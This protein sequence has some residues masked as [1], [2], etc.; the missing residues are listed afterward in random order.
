MIKW[1]NENG[2]KVPTA[3]YTY[4]AG[5]EPT[6]YGSPTDDNTFDDYMTDLLTKNDFP[7]LLPPM[8]GGPNTDIA[9]K[10]SLNAPSFAEAFLKFMKGTKQPDKYS[11]RAWLMLAPQ[12]EYV[13]SSGLHAQTRPLTIQQWASMDILTDGGSRDV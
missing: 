11:T 2:G 12:P 7:M 8:T 1:L 6:W 3:D 5:M 4:S 9:T 10:S 13:I